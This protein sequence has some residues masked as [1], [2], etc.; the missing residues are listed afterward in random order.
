MGQDITSGEGACA[1]AEYRAFDFWVGR[2]DVRPFKGG[3]I[4]AHSLIERKYEGC[5]IRENWMP[6]KGDG[7]GSLSSYDS[8]DGKWHQY[9]VDSSG[10]IVRFSGGM[11][12]GEMV[13]TGLWLDFGGP[14]RDGL[15]RM[16]Y[17]IEANGAVRQRGEVSFDDGGHWKPA[18]DLLYRRAREDADDRTAGDTDTDG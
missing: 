3:D 1:G 16:T 9:W 4:V 13:L 5:A 11:N 8:R 7:G 10:A 17:T 14:G 18:F 6:L 15:V 2:W 12:H